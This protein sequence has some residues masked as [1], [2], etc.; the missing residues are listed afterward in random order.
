[1][2]TLV[3]AFALLVLGILLSSCSDRDD[4]LTSPNIRIQNLS[5]QNFVSVVVRTD[6]LVFE[7]VNADSFSEYLAFEVAYEQDTLRIEADSTSLVFIPDTI[8][9]PLPI[10]LYTYQLNIDEEGELLF[11]FKID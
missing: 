7:N 3:P 2:K 10:G 11:N 6:T 8:T 5:N 4:N 9:S 1:M